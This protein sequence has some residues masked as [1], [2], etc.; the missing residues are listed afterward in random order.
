M[1]SNLNLEQGI[2]TWRQTC[3]CVYSSEY[4][5][6]MSF[7][8]ACYLCLGKDMGFVQLCHQSAT[9]SWDSSLYISSEY[10]CTM[11]LIFY[12]M[13]II[14]R[15][16]KALVSTVYRLKG[17]SYIGKSKISSFRQYIDTD[18]GVPL[19]PYS[20]GTWTLSTTLGRPVLHSERSLL[21]S[22]PSI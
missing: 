21:S 10:L 11:D 15:N 2:K 3:V 12:N 20:V 17:S 4:S 16:W 1:F 6:L 5:S 22:C 18:S 7:P 13:E 14:N 9:R 8:W 19:N